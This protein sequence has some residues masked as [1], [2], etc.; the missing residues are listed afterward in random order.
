[1]AWVPGSRS[2]F[3]N[4]LGYCFTP[5]QRLWLYNGAP[6]VAFYDTLGIRTMYSR[7][8]PPASSRGYLSHH[9]IAE[10]SL[11]VT[12]NHNQ[13]QQH[14]N[15][16]HKV[17]RLK[18]EHDVHIHLYL[19]EQNSILFPELSKDFFLVDAQEIFNSWHN[20]APMNPCVH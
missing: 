6:L 8:K 3:G 12:L 14:Y 17:K 19:T 11:N 18:S 2:K 20:I 7:L 16:Y 10:I 15:T 1:M 4:W 5:Y 13:Q 9:Y